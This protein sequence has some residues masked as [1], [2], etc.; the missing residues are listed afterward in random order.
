MKRESSSLLIKYIVCICIA[1]LITVG[2]FAIEGFFTSDLARNIQ[3]LGDGFTVSGVLFTLFAGM[4]FISSEG[5]L[6]GIGFVVRN[7]ILTFFPMGRLKHER[8]ADYRERKMKEIKKSGDHCIL[9]TGLV[10]L[11]I[12]IIFTVIWYLNFYNVTV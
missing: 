2:I 7:A 8:Y 12:G 9:V 6:V 4:L 3:V 10:F 1:A 11:A 5:A